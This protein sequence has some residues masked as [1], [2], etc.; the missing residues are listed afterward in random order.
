M[1][2]RRL[3]DDLL[4]LL[5]AVLVAVRWRAIGCDDRFEI[6]PL[7]ALLLTITRIAVSSHCGGSSH[8]DFLSVGFHGL[9]DVGA[10]HHGTGRSGGCECFFAGWEGGFL[11]SVSRRNG[12]L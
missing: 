11:C 4:Y 5:R 9:L 1:R 8:S 7:P 10:I 3:W 2:S 12:E 6:I